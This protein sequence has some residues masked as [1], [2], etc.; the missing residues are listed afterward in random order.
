MTLDQGDKFSLDEAVRDARAEIDALETTQPAA[1]V[2]AAGGGTHTDLNAAIGDISAGQRIVVVSDLDISEPIEIDKECEIEWLF[3]C[4]LRIT[5]ADL[6]GIKSSSDVGETAF[7]PRVRLKNPRIVKGSGLAGGD[8]GGIGI[9]FHGA[10]HWLVEN[11]YVHTFATGYLFDASPYPTGYC[12]LNVVTN[13]EAL[14]CTTG[15]HANNTGAN[16]NTFDGAFYRCTRSISHEGG[17][18]FMVP[19]VSIEHP[20]GVTTSAVK[21]SASGLTI[22]ASYIEALEAAP[23]VEIASGA[24]GY[25]IR[26]FVSN[27]GAGTKLTV[28]D[29]ATGGFV[30]LESDTIQVVRNGKTIQFRRRSTAAHDAIA[31]F[32]GRDSGGTSDVLRASIWS[33]GKFR[34]PAPSALPSTSLS[35]GDLAMRTGDAGAELV[36]LDHND[37]WQRVLRQDDIVAQLG[38]DTSRIETLPRDMCSG[39]LTSVSGTVYFSYFT[40]LWDLTIDQLRAATSSAFSGLTLAR[41]GLYTVAANGDVTLV[42]RT[43]SDTSLFASGN[44]LYPKALDTTGGYPATY[45]LVRGTRYAAANIVVGSSPGQLRGASLGVA[46]T[47][48]TP[49]LAKQVTGQAD[50]PTSVV[51]ASLAA[52]GNRVW[53]AMDA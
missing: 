41:M 7:V 47:G 48:V 33:D 40:P 49:V 28:A 30:D 25:N 18:G 3:G 8:K 13:A 45:D 4:E 31:D 44:T 11:P 32:Y 16:A 24:N 35:D 43:A 52:G 17:L 21:T 2:D 6:D 23:A 36:Q 20:S 42:A 10:Y 37:D 46:I 5:V 26:G 38:L 51:A 39:S 15:L 29:G 34:L 53:M 22:S 14:S 1:V 19:H 27:Q 12:F 50:L 9:N